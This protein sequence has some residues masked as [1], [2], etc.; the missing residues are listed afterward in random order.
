[1]DADCTMT[2]LPVQPGGLAAAHSSPALS[3]TSSL[4][5]SEGERQV[6]EAQLVEG[7]DAGAGELQPK[8]KVV[9]T[10]DARVSALKALAG[11]GTVVSKSR[12]ALAGPLGEGVGWLRA[13][14][15]AARRCRTRASPQG[16]GDI[17]CPVQRP[18]RARVVLRSR[19]A[20]PHPRAGSRPR[21]SLR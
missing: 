20:A 7:A 16:P 19:A 12:Q 6:E 18:R 8:A 15:P 21:R 5:S 13:R 10:V 2:A 3:E 14:A 4:T 1:M 9:K 11:I 17:P